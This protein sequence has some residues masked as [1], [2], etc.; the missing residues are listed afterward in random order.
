MISFI[1]N[2]VSGVIV[3]VIIGTL[4]EMILPESKNKKYV[5]TVIGLFILFTIV[6]PFIEKFSNGI[7]FNLDDYEQFFTS[8][9]TIEVANVNLLQEE[10]IQ[11]VYKENLKQEIITVIEQKGFK[12][13]KIDVSISVEESNYGE[14]TKLELTIDKN[15]NSIVIDINNTKPSNISSDEE[16]IIL[17]LLYDNFNVLEKDVI[18][19]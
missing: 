4:I 11:D 14:I 17:K 16:A 13:K 8:S 3:A 18:I 7:E 10:N 15:I 2:W 5:K 9:E 6:S 19:N 1:N 12:V